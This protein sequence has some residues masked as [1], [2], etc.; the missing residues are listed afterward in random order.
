V[1]A[2]FPLNFY[3][4]PQRD[5]NPRGPAFAADAAMAFHG[6]WIDCGSGLVCLNITGSPDRI[7][8]LFRHVQYPFVR[9]PGRFLSRAA[10]QEHFQQQCMR[11]LRVGNAL[12]I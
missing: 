6:F 11:F 10:R 5:A 7:D 8:F 3:A 12:F 4:I 1:Q 2:G 9:P